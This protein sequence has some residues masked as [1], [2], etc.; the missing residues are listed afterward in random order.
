MTYLDFD[1]RMGRSFTLTKSHIRDESLVPA[2]AYQVRHLVLRAGDFDEIPPQI[3]LFNELTHLVLTGNRIHVLPRGIP[4][5]RSLEVL[6]Y[7]GNGLSQI[8]DLVFEMTE[9]RGLDLRANRLTDLPPE[10]G[11]LTE[12]RELRLNRNQISSLPRTLARTALREGVGPVYPRGGLYVSG[13]PLPPE[14]AKLASQ[15]Q[16]MA[17]I[18]VLDFI[19]EP[20]VFNESISFGVTSG[21]EVAASTPPPIP[22]PPPAPIKTK[23]ADGRIVL[24]DKYL[25]L[26]K[27]DKAD[28][29]V[30]WGELKR[31][32]TTLCLNVKTN[33]PGLLRRLR[34]YVEALGE[35]FPAFNEIRLGLNGEALAQAVNSADELLLPDS[36]GE[37]RGLVASHIIFMRHFPRWLEYLGRSAVERIDVAAVEQARSIFDTILTH[38]ADARALIDAAVLEALKDI[39]DL[40]EELGV[41]AHEAWLGLLRSLDDLAVNVAR[42]ALRFM[43]DTRDKA[44]DLG[45]TL[46]ARLIVYGIGY[47]LLKITGVGSELFGWLEPIIQHLKALGM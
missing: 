1:G 10:I 27:G 43:Q 44:T 18:D 2:D 4:V 6:D 15:E 7:Q 24:D 25:P 30:H 21:F 45:S 23:V 36:I 13:N 5:L 20:R 9:L 19:G 37:L 28:L 47:Q 42:F 11:E 16:P 31:D 39:K 14:L 41:T 32:A 34:D 8:P 35:D 33:A 22:D 46:A 29:A 12:L 38:L 40:A 26:S 3:V 17:T